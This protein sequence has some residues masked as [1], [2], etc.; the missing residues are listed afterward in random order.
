MAISDFPSQDDGTKLQR[1]V[2]DAVDHVL[3]CYIKW[4]ED[5]ATVRDA[6]GRWSAA[7][8]DA[9]ETGLFAVYLAALDQEVTSMS[10]VGRCLR[11]LGAL[12][13]VADGVSRAADGVTSRLGVGEGLIGDDRG[14]L[15]R[16]VAAVSFAAR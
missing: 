2:A 14:D 4:R 10:R 3:A 7:P 13:S 8:P 1:R 12:L 16:A 11:V 15:R 6:Y 9:D 5:A